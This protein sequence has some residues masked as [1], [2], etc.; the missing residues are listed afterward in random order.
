MIPKTAEGKEILVNIP[1][2]IASDGGIPSIAQDDKASPTAKGEEIPDAK[3]ED[4]K[5]MEKASGAIG[6][7]GQAAQPEASYRGKEIV[8][9][10]PKLVGP[11]NGEQRLT[12]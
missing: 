10:V 12:T 1:G 4:E 8:V 5:K 9:S 7:S 11:L 2:A 6:V 3:Q